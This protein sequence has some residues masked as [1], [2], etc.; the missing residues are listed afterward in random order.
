MTM[1]IACAIV[2]DFENFFSLERVADAASSLTLV[3]SSHMDGSFLIN[4]MLA[5]RLGRRKAAASLGSKHTSEDVDRKD[6]LIVLVCLSQTF[7][8]YKSVQ[9]KF[10]NAIKLLGGDENDHMLVVELLNA[11]GK[12]DDDDDDAADSGDETK[13]SKQLDACVERVRLFLSTRL[14]HTH[15]TSGQPRRRVHIFV[16]DLSVALLV[17]VAATSLLR[18]VNNLSTLNQTSVSLVV[19]CRSFE[20]QQDWLGQWSSSSSSSSSSTQLVN[21]LVASADH[22]IRVDNLTTG[23]MKDINGKVFE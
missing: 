14:S 10:G 18:F 1:N 21:D 9:S 3:T 15:D 6:D 2:M 23:Y 20:Q 12:Y 8:H 22:V 19:F 16:D 7:S 13:M 17:G 5:E 4:Y 11:L